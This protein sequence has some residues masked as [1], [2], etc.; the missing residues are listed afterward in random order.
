M[1]LIT[2]PIHASNAWLLRVGGA[3]KTL[4]ILGL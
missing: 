2:K 4:D 1:V 3:D